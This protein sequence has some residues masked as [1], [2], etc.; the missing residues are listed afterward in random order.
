[1]PSSYTL[2]DIDKRTDR[3]SFIA[4]KT[5]EF[6][7]SLLTKNKKN[8]ITAVFKGRVIFLHSI[9]LIELI[10]VKFCFKV[11]DGFQPSSISL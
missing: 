3:V 10:L 9:S 5:Y 7:Y 8:L 11:S 6:S 1:M 2:T 4:I